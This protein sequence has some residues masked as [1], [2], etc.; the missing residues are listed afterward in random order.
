MDKT[1]VNDPPPEWYHVANWL[2]TLGA[3]RW[4]PW[5]VILSLWLLGDLLVAP[6]VRSTMVTR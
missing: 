6:D 3:T 4:P 2:P 5:D 1:L